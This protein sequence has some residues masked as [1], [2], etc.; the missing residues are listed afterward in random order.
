MVKFGI[1]LGWG[2]EE[3]SFVCLWAGDVKVRQLLTDGGLL[4]EF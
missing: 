4:R 1:L 2:G 3:K